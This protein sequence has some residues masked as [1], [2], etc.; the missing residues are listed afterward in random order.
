MRVGVVLMRTLRNGSVEEPFLRRPGTGGRRFFEIGTRGS[1]RGPVPILRRHHESIN[2]VEFT[3]SAVPA[4]EETP[5][6]D[7]A[8]A[9]ASERHGRVTAGCGLTAPRAD[10]AVRAIYGAGLRKDWRDSDGADY[11]RR[12]KS[13]AEP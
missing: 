4:S 6:R 8:V 11:D 1:R 9:L 13:S 10:E 3:R 7:R 12:A 5:H 2:F